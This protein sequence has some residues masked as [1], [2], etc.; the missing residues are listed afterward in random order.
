MVEK[1]EN[2]EAITKTLNSTEDWYRAVIF[3]AQAQV[4]AK[5]NY[6]PNENELK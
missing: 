6:E 1:I 4:V 3:D 2:A 5:K